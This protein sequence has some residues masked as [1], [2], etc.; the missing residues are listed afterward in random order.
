M[1][2]KMVTR[3]SRVRV[4]R[5]CLVLFISSGCV[6]R[7]MIYDVLV[8]VEKVFDSMLLHSGGALA[9]RCPMLAHPLTF[10]GIE[11]WFSCTFI[12]SC[13]FNLS[14]FSFCIPNDL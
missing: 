1:I 14:K 4:G 7:V 6:W 11:R 8:W 3:R 5:G 10:D 13:R 12:H 9:V 2:T